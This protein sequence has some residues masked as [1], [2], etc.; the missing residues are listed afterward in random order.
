MDSV[1]LR[2]I[3]EKAEAYDKNLLATDPRFRRSVVIAHE[4]GTHLQFESAFLLRIESV[5]IACFTEHH[6]VHVYHVEDLANYSE[7]E[8]RYVPIEE[9]P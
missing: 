8:R 6:G 4:D 5:W 1:P 3:R 2:K 9:L 7:F